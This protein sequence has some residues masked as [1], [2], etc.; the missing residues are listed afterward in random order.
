MLNYVQIRRGKL[1]KIKINSILGDQKFE[2]L[3]FFHFWIFEKKWSNETFY[4]F[5]Q[6]K[7]EFLNIILIYEIEILFIN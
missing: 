1:V 4:N 5:L 2:S 7:L 6:L 3:N